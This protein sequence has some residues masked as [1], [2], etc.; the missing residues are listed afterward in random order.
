MLILLPL[1]L[2]HWAPLT[3]V[4]LMQTAI[5]LTAVGYMKRLDVHHLHL[6]DITIPEFSFA[7]LAILSRLR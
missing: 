5:I 1:P 7:N 4:P 6:E 3:A 2:H